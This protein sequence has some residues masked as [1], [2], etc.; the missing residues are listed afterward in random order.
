MTSGCTGTEYGT[1]TVRTLLS[2]FFLPLMVAGNLGGK[3]TLLEGIFSGMTRYWVCRVGNEIL[4]P[5][6]NRMLRRPLRRAKKGCGG[7]G[8]KV[9]CTRPVSEVTIVLVPVLTRA[10]V[11]VGTTKANKVP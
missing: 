1:S 6:S 7:D 2:H 5:I 8:G 9:P 4:V 3:Y 11:V 10:V